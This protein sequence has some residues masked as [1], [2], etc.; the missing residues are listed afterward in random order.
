MLGAAL[1]VGLLP[2]GAAQARE[3]TIVYVVE[4]GD[5]LYGLAQRGLVRLADY[6]A[7]QRQNRIANPRRLR[8]GAKLNVPVRLLRTE[9]VAARVGA[10][11]GDVTV[12]SGGRASQVA[13]GAV[14]KEGDSFATGANAFGRLDLPDGSRL[15]LPSQSRVR[16]VRLQ[17]TFLTGAVERE[18]MVEAGSGGSLV[19]PLRNPK[20]TY[21]MRTPLS[22]SAVRGTE[23]R[24]RYAADEG[25]ASTEV[26]E[27]SVEVRSG[28]SQAVVGEAQALLSSPDGAVTPAAL[29]PAPIL[30]RAGEVQQERDLTFEVVPSATARAYHA[31]LATDAGFVEIIADSVE[32][33]AKVAFD[34]LADGV[35]FVRAS[36]IDTAGLEG[37]ASTYA[38][39]R[40]LNVLTP[41]APTREAASVARR[42]LFRWDVEGEGTRTY[43]FQLRREGG[44]TLP[45]VDQPGLSDQRITLTDLPPG[46]YVWRVMSRTFVRG[47][48]VDKWSAEQ[49]FEN[50]G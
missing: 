12:I 33:D 31:Q 37:L 25:R 45:M 11:K 35:Y 10:F 28:D 6:K 20:D 47:Q 24:V 26:V 32:P 27:G 19:R 38:F 43:R 13:V 48:Y 17:H 15:T 34:P 29:P 50:E 2:A 9:P 21:I 1:A 42:Y 8:V 18:F 14:L 49:R 44:D 30:R 36:V 40:R 16:V 39:E 3:A 23:F 7:V 46:I 5:T 4:R 41:R 22:V